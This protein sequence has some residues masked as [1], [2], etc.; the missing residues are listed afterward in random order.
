MAIHSLLGTSLNNSL[1][2]WIGS[3]WGYDWGLI[4]NIKGGVGLY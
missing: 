2:G 1:E 3:N 4:K